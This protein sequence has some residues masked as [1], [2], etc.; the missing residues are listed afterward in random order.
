[1]SRSGWAGS[2]GSC[3]LARPRHSLL[4]TGKAL[5]DTVASDWLGLQTGRPLFKS[6][7]NLSLQ[8][9]AAPPLTFGFGLPLS[10]GEPTPSK[11]CKPS[12]RLSRIPL[13]LTVTPSLPSLARL[14]L[15]AVYGLVRAAEISVL[16]HNQQIEAASRSM[17]RRALVSRARVEKLIDEGLEALQREMERTDTHALDRMRFLL[18]S[19]RAVGNLGYASPMPSCQGGR[20]QGKGE[21]RVPGAPSELLRI[22]HCTG[23]ATHGRTGLC[24]YQARG[25]A[26]IDFSR[27]LPTPLAST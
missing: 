23:S 18:S 6:W 3:Y 4:R 12:R 21:R 19:I 25:S 16:L 13:L 7:T 1:M 2:S 8:A 11:S 26:Q 10:K 27:P 5:L 20:M 15:S 14:W 22:N 24:E 9:S 17:L